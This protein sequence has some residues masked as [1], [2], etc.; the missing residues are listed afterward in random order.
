MVESPAAVMISAACIT[1]VTQPMYTTAAIPISF[2]IVR[3]LV[4]I[5]LYYG[6]MAVLSTNLNI[7]NFAAITPVKLY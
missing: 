5:V 7:Q 6:L 3:S 4:A 1:P 2:N